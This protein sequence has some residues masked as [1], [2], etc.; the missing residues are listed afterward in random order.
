MS[1]VAT[2]PLQRTMADAI[3][4]SQ[5]KLAVTQ[6]RLSTGKKVNFFSDLGTETV[7]NLSA[8]T[9]LT[10]QDAHTAVA[11]RVGTTLSLYDS[12][13]SGIEAAASDIREGMLT[14]IG[15]GQ[16]SGLQAAI[17]AAFH[18][19]R[20]SLN[21]NEGGVPLFAGGQTDREPFRPAKLSDLVGLDAADA[22]ADDGVVASARVSEGVDVRYGITAR[23]AG[24]GL[25]AAFRALA[26]A[27]P[28]G[29]QPT[30]AQKTALAAIVGQ[31]QD[32]ITSLRAVSADNGRRQTQVETLATRGE[33]RALVLHGVI[34]A[35]EDADLGQVA[36][37][38]AQQKT[39]L[40]ASYSVFA[41]LTGLSLVQ[42]I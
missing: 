4:R 2:I 1:R 20:T 3:A 17:D 30:D 34:E 18:Q 15:T 42:F 6:T 10:R 23:A 14:A 25:Y 41:Q 16:S 39:M 27:G 9:L 38:L 12:H 21:A 26:E 28:I 24:D 32:G 33:Q 11:K 35:N 13:L 7:R 8:H 37:D 19:Y 36:I 29:E 22:F 31:V 5:E 40:E